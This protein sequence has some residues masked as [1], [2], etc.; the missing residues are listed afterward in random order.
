[1]AEIIIILI[2]FHF[3]FW[4]KFYTN[5]W[6]LCTSEIVSNEYPHWLWMGRQLRKRIWPMK[7]NIYYREPGSIPFLCT[8]YPP[9]FIT[10]FISTLCNKNTSFKL[11]SWLI[12]IHSFLGSLFSYILM[13]KYLHFGQLVSLFGAL[14]LA[15][16]AYVIRPQTACMMF[17]MAW[18]PACLINGWIGCLAFGLAILG[19]YWPIILTGFPIFLYNPFCFWGAVLALP[20]IIP[21]LRYWPKT[22]RAKRRPTSSWGRMPLKRYFFSLRWPENGMIHYPEYSFGVGICTFLALLRPTTWWIPAIIGVLGSQGLFVLDRIPAR[23]VYLVSFAVIMA[24]IFALKASNSQDILI[25]LIILQGF[26]LWK[27]RDIYPS[28]PFSQWW[29]K[30]DEHKFIGKNWPNNTGYMNEEHH[31]DYYGGF[32]LAENYRD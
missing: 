10:A 2:I 29:R 25:P 11:Y 22:I 13:Y 30:I 8:F 23:F 4:W 6:R 28:F 19:G 18:I 12:Y 21:F 15:Y 16:N 7:D 31:Y 17:T 1:M 9:Y 14:S 24:S 20:Q 26:L 3:A 27:N 5:P 32:A